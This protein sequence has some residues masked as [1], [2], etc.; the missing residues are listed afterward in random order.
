MLCISHLMYAAK[1]AMKKREFLK[2][3]K[4]QWG[5]ALIVSFLLFGITYITFDVIFS[6]ND[7][8]R[9]MY[10]LAGYNTGEP[11]PYHPFI[12]YFLGKAISTGYYLI[13]QLP[14]YALFHIIC[15]FVGTVGVGKCLIKLSVKRNVTIIL[16]IAIHVFLFYSV[17]IF[18]IV[19]MQFSTTPAV[20]GSAS[21]T[22]IYSLD[23]KNDSKREICC[24][25]I[26][27]VF[28]L[29]VCYMTRS[30]TW[31]CVMC[32]FALAVLCQILLIYKQDKK[33]IWKWI[34]IL[35][36][37]ILLT[38][39][40]V[41][42]LRCISL[43]MKSA[44]E[45][46]VAFDEYNK[47]RI[48]FQDYGIYVDYY[49]DPEFYEQLGWSENIYRAAFGLLFFDEEMNAEN[50][51]QITEKYKRDV[52]P[53]GIEDVYYTAKTIFDN[54]RVA[55]TGVAVLVILCIFCIFFSQKYNELQCEK[56]CLLFAVMGYL[57][58]FL[59]LSYKGRLPIRT[60]MVIT[61]SAV[62]YLSITLLKVIDIKIIKKKERFAAI[63]T[64]C[65]C[66]TVLY[67]IR[68]VYFTDDCTKT[69]TQ[70]TAVADQVLS[71]ENYV[72]ENP[73]NVYVYDFTVATLQRE[74]FV[75]YPDKKPINCIV[76]GGSYTFSTIYYKQL[77]ENE[78]SSLYWRDFLKDNIFYASSDLTFVDLM[79]ANIQENV[80]KPIHYEEVKSFGE[81]GV[82][83]YKFL[84]DINLEKEDNG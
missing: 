51:R 70:T 52:E 37:S 10:A 11:Y 73:E 17:L 26:L 20:L 2:K 28:F 30:F 18:P 57:M 21:I 33:Q 38:G 23:I 58:M 71:F 42:T 84:L 34:G 12:N 65:M 43:S 27:A 55:K 16:P 22:L 72:L 7:D 56:F 44:V 5:I 82:K 8:L 35:A 24:D 60:F 47:Y 32:F 1:A 13:P 74:P 75:V 77:E 61:I 81:E 48:E 6:T 62:T 53:R 36:G 25:L 14:W 40:I 59:Y 3:T 79:A 83:I 63:G 46:N 68:A 67:N 49:S 29:L 15:L 54:Y 39:S 4:W 66:L 78:L 41:F 64:M 19:S 69:Q 80:G 76:S 45:E 9:I 50:L 31:Y